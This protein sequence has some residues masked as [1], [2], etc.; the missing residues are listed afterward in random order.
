MLTFEPASS[1]SMDLVTSEA[2]GLREQLQLAL[3]QMSDCSVAP[4]PWRIN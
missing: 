2:T 3:W 4:N 1:T